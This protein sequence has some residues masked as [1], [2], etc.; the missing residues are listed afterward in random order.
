MV[1][2][3]HKTV[4]LLYLICD[5]IAL[6]ASW[7]VT[8]E[9]RLAIDS[10][11]PVH[12]DRATLTQLVPPSTAIVCLWSV[13]A[14]W[15]GF[16]NRQ[17]TK[18]RAVISDV[19]QTVLVVAALTIILVFFY[20]D[21]TNKV[22][23]SFLFASIPVNFGFLFLGRL[24]A[25]SMGKHID[26]RWTAP[27]RIAVVGTE[28]E[29]T[30]KYSDIASASDGDLVGAIVP[31]ASGA[32]TVG[33]S[34]RIVG[35]CDRLA[36]H[37]NHEKLTQIVLFPDGVPQH[38]IE[39]CSQI[40]KR[41]GIVIL[42]FAGTTDPASRV[43]FTEQNGLNMIR[44]TPVTFTRNQEIVKRVLDIVGTV[45]LLV[46]LA[47]LLLA[48]AIGVKLSSSGPVLYGSWRVGRGGKHFRFLKFRSMFTDQIDRSELLRFNEKSGH[49]F[50]LKNDP[51]VTP[52]GRILR[53][54]SLD[55]LPQLI[56]VLRGEMSL[57]G[58]RPL[59][60][61]DLEPDGLSSEYSSWAEQ[62]A[63]VLPGITGL[64]QI[65]GRS[66]LSFDDMARLDQ[67]YIQNWSLLLDLRILLQTPLVVITGEG[68][69]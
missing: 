40:A 54:Y 61:E 55:E 30:S 19:A 69:Y 59:P 22:S 50:K 56:N 32:R 7:H 49:L 20:A 51:R 28:Q 58:P 6:I 18:L 45:I 27:D 68:A 66:E 24:A 33:Q 21:S 5:V 62:R 39:N 11:M 48:I 25:N 16:H 1:H 42:R 10:W 38:E 63:Q 23:R 15:V 26:R 44:I 8:F 31:N 47:P 35:S 29:L 36:E 17:N 3:C 64:W 37:I 4:I 43:Q 53:R 65:S 12:L 14:I 67:H 57:I 13:I 52:L 9:L 2:A 34:L 60:A 46:L 41:M